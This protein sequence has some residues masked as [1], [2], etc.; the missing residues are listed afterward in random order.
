M[1]LDMSLGAYLNDLPTEILFLILENNT[2]NNVV[3]AP[4]LLATCKCWAVLIDQFYAYLRVP[5]IITYQLAQLNNLGDMYHMATNCIAN[6]RSSFTINNRYLDALARHMIYLEFTEMPKDVYKYSILMYIAYN[7]IKCFYQEGHLSTNQYKLLHQR[8]KWSMSVLWCLL[9][10]FEAIILTN[11]AEILS[12]KYIDLP[13]DL[14]NWYANFLVDVLNKFNNNL[15][16]DIKFKV[17]SVC[18]NI[19]GCPKVVIDICK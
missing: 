7:T 2:K 16:R 8:D 13:R 14:F 19:L 3:I 4:H 12:N 10:R 5:R 11:S 9:D 17:V 18:N 6:Q 1:P 15:N